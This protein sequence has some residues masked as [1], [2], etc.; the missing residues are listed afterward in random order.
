MWPDLLFRI[1]LAADVFRSLGLVRAALN[2]P[3]GGHD[4]EHELEVFRLPV[5]EHRL[6]E[7]GREDVA[8]VRDG[9]R[10]MLQLVLV[11]RA[12]PRDRLTD[13]RGQEEDEE[14]ERERLVAQPERH[15]L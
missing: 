7:V 5:L 8:H 14:K 15:Q 10:S 13:E 11:E 4:E 12:L 3:D 9:L 1:R 6:P 2:Q